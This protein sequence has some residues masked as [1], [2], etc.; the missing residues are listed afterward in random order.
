MLFLGF[1]SSKIIQ[2]PGKW[3][4]AFKN[5]GSL[6][7]TQNGVY[8]VGK[9]SPHPSKAFCTHLEPPSCHISKTY[10]LEGGGPLLTGGH[11]KATEHHTPR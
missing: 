2:F 7:S 5:P 4:K 11:V 1:I 9:S 3:A 8:P 6:T 10:F